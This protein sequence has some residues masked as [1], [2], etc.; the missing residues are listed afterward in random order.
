MMATYEELRAALDGH[1]AKET[2]TRRAAIE[3]TSRS[4]GRLRPSEP[5]PDPAVMKAALASLRA[6]EVEDKRLRYALERLQEHP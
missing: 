2:E 3:L 4:S 5:A 1:Q 6:W